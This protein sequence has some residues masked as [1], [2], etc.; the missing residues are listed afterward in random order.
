[1]KNT[2]KIA[3]AAGTGG[4]L[5]VGGTAAIAAAIIDDPDPRPVQARLANGSGYGYGPGSMS[6]N[7]QS[8]VNGNGSNRNGNGMGNRAGNGAGNRAGNGMGMGQQGG[9]GQQ[10]GIAITAQQGTLTAEQ[11]TALAGMAE[12]EKLAHDLYIVFAARYDNQIFDRI[13]AAE[14]RHLEAVQTLLGRY[15]VADPTKDKAAGTFTSAAV[16]ATYDKLLAQGQ[17]NEQAALKVGKAVE[18]DDI[19]KLGKAG[20]GVTAPDVKQVYD[21]LLAGSKMHLAAFERWIS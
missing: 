16:K 3:I 14:A 7:R 17:A 15:Q 11:K 10:A 13:S 21:H 18:E 1:M 19:S 12:E 4:L 6:M 8:S 5:L 20:S 9:A 2:T